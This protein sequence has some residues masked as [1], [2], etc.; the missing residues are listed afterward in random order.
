RCILII[1]DEEYSY[2]EWID[3]E[4]VKME[5]ENPQKKPRIYLYFGIFILVI[6]LN[7][8]VFPAIQEQTIEEVDYGTFLTMIDDGQV[9]DVEIDQNQIKYTV[10]GEKNNIYKTGI[11][12][13]PDLVTRLHEANVTF[14][15][16]IPK[17]NSPILSFVLMWIIPIML[18]IFLGQFLMRRMGGGSN[19]ALTFGKSNAKI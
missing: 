3:K 14:T 8:Y 4:R 10:D 18:F 15:K 11:T 16:K 17:E 13:D 6:L 7:A 12:D 9:A 5:E 2:F 1:C 19:R